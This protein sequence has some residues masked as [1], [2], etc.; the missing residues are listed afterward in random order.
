M[1]S[2]PTG[3][4]VTHRGLVEGYQGLSTPE[5]MVVHGLATLVLGAL[6]LGLLPGYGTNTL[7]V[8]R[9]S[10]IISLCIGLPGATVL[11]GLLA[12]GVLISGTNLG[13]FFGMPLVV[14]TVTLL[15]AWTALGYIAFGAAIAHRIGVE[16]LWAWVVAG[17][18]LSALFTA[19]PVVFL[20]ATSLA[21]AV[22][23]GA[24]VRGLIGGGGLGY[25]EERVVPPAE[26]V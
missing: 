14:L 15:P 7:G 16:A 26:K 22:G 21:A 24:G 12:T 6:V 17:A 25:R 23:V 5:T 4:P 18:A 11:V 20:A 19:V 13:V 9:R 10:P 2:D 8:S 1:G 3:S